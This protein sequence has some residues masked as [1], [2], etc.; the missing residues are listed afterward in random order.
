MLFQ[1][2]DLMNIPEYA[3]LLQ[4]YNKDYNYDHE[5]INQFSCPTSL[6][7]NPLFTVKIDQQNFTLSMLLHLFQ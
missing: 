5:N 6:Y 7:E 4:D 3:D 1:E 2:K